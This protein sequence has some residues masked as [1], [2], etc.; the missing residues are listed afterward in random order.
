MFALLRALLPA[1]RRIPGGVPETLAAAIRAGRDVALRGGNRAR[2]LEFTLAFEEDDVV[3]SPTGFERHG[4]PF[5][6]VNAFH[7]AGDADALFVADS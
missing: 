5:G 1:L 3:S 4:I 7:V 6:A 2:L